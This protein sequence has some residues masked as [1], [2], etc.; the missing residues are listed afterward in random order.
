LRHVKLILFLTLILGLS[1]APATLLRFFPNE[2]LDY[3]LTPLWKTIE[4]QT[5][6]PEPFIAAI[7]LLTTFVVATAAAAALLLVLVREFSR[8]L[9]KS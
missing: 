9:R 2:T 1:L 8:S 3:L 6:F 5:G 7:G 4:S